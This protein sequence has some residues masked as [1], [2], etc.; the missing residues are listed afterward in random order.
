MKKLVV[1]ALCILSVAL[2]NVACSQNGTKSFVDSALDAMDQIQPDPYAKG[3]TYSYSPSQYNFERYQKSPCYDKLGFSPY[4]DQ[5]QQESDYCDCE[6]KYYRSLAW[7]I[8]IS[9]AVLA[10]LAFLVIKYYKNNKQKNTSVTPENNDSSTTNKKTTTNDATASNP[11]QWLHQSDGTSVDVKPIDSVIKN[12]ASEKANLSPSDELNQK[13]EQLKQLHKSGLLTDKELEEKATTIKFDF[14]ASQAL[15]KIQAIKQIKKDQL[16]SA[17][18]SG[19]LS[20]AEAQIK[21]KQIEDS[22]VCPYCENVSN[23][24]DEFCAK[25]FLNN[26][27]KLPDDVDRFYCECCGF[28]NKEYFDICPVC[29]L[30]GNESATQNSEKSD[31]EIWIDENGKQALI[32]LVII[33]LG[34]LVAK[35]L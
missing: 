33:I 15:K 27:G 10:V 16:Q 20:E 1:L 11:N 19:V 22:V 35:I 7:K 12:S 24:S 4:R 9:L 23:K 34:G 18:A 25:C 32:V 21:I 17:V 26:A 31:L 28:E 13:L 2:S 5:A 3:R 29:R 30:K 14:R 6:D 8:G